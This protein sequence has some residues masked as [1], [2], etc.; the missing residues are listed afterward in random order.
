M[1]DFDS[2][3]TEDFWNAVK[4]SDHEFQALVRLAWDELAG[5]SW[6]LTDVFTGI[7]YEKDGN[8][9]FITRNVA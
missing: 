2:F 9:I 6:R 5:K 8:E 3:H 1:K 7:V 4:L